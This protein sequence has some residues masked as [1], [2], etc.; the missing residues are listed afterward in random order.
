[1]NKL[2]L[3]GKFTD[4]FR[5]ISKSFTGKYEMKTC[6][7]KPDMFQGIIKISNPEI[8]VF[9]MEQLSDEDIH[10]LHNLQTNYA[11]I[12]VVCIGLNPD[13]KKIS[14]FT[15]LPNFVFLPKDTEKED[16]LETVQNTL[17]STP[18]AGEILE[19][20]EALPAFEEAEENSTLNPSDPKSKRQKKLI[21]LVDDSGI[22][23]RMMKNLIGNKYD[24]CMTTSGVDAVPMILSRRPD[25]ILLDYEMPVLDGPQTM[26]KIREHEEI[27]DI[28][29]VFVTAV[30][31][32]DHIK[33]V[34]DLKPAGYLLKPVD[35]KRLLQTIESIVGE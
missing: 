11:Y 4:L 20:I 8:V 24:I 14:E 13:N 33:A 31:S 2:L 28:P 10:I 12:P 32:K 16:L 21:M 5:K 7:N 9:V 6:V 29:I 1:M 3:V 18:K 19:E 23:L 35:N 15:A 22:Y 26:K 25:L 17:D 30:N 34:L 27:C